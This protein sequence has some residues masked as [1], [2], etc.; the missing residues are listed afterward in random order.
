ME[1]IL[2]SAWLWVDSVFLEPYPFDNRAG[3]LVD[4]LLFTA[5]R[6]T[7]RSSSRNHQSAFLYGRNKGNFVA[8]NQRSN[9]PEFWF[10]EGLA[11][12]FPFGEGGRS[13]SSE[14]RNE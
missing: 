7:S 10:K 12:G 5:E 8:R 9:S 1:S 11:A 6:I 13:A 4:A 3:S 2:A 14:S